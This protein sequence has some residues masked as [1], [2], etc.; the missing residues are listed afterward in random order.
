MLQNRVRGLLL[1]DLITWVL[2]VWHFI[3]VVVSNQNN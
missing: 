3:F 2:R 1:L